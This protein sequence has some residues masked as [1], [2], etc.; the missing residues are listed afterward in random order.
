MSDI[1]GNPGCEGGQVSYGDTNPCGSE[2]A[3]DSSPAATS[4]QL[5]HRHREQARSHRGSTLNAASTNTTK[6]VGAGLAREGGITPPLKPT[7]YDADSVKA[8]SEE[9]GYESWL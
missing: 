7:A 5:T 4:T 6:P 9:A 8:N 1:R 2:L 3:R